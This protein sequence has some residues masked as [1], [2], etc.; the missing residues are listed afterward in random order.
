MKLKKDLAVQYK[1]WVKARLTTIRVTGLFMSLLAI[2]LMGMQFFGI[3]DG[4][5]NCVSL[6]YICGFLFT[7]N[8][9][10]QDMCL[11]KKWAKASRIIATILYLAT[12]SLCVLVILDRFFVISI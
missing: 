3:V 1:K 8:A 2:F 5:M 9:Q 4:F 6:V 11:K 12:V 7:L 10:Y